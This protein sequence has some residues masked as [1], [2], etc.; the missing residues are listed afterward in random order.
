MKKKY[1]ERL[2]N[3]IQKRKTLLCMGIDPDLE[4][5]QANN[6]QLKIIHSVKQSLIDYFLPLI[7]LCQKFLIAVKPNIAFFEQ[8]GSEGLEALRVIIAEAKK[9][10]LLVI[11]D[12]KRGDI[13]NTSDAYAK[14][15]FDEFQCD[16]LTLSPYLGYDSLLPFF[17]KASEHSG[18]VYVLIKTSNP[19]SND[20][21]NLNVEVTDKDGKMEKIPLYLA[22]AKSLKK[23][24]ADNPLVIGGVFGATHIREFLMYVKMFTPDS[25]FPLLVPGIGIQGGN[26][27]DFIK[28][29]K[30]QNFPLKMLLFNSSRALIYN[31]SHPEKNYYENAVLACTEFKREIEKYL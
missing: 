30:D 6:P 22:V 26:L 19:G 21:Q 12:A 4:K 24:T 7:E 11:L 29:A 9:L 28:T 18:F 2:K 23:W 20:F 25:A 14:A 3:Y 16:A 10:E 13:G 17:K 1:I 8:Y 31:N 27:Q 5:M 15:C